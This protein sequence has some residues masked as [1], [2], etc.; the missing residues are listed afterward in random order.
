M[1]AYALFQNSEAYDISLVLAGKA[2]KDVANYIIGSV[3]EP[4]NG[5]NSGRGDCVAFISP[6][7]ITTG[8]VIVGSDSEQITATNAYRNAL[9]SSSYAVLDSGYKYQYDRYNDKYRWIPLNGDVAG[10]CART[11]YTN[12]P[13]WSPGGLNRGQIK[14]VVRLAV[15]PNKT[16]R[17]SLYKNG[18]N[19]VV[20][21]PGEGTVLFEIG[22]AHV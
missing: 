19:P 11:D 4:A 12:D 17:D 18:V 3:C 1:T 15:N 14:N 16:M 2:S 10:L 20:T 5:V 6:E 21:F 7:S 13:W 22:R 8:D 9:T